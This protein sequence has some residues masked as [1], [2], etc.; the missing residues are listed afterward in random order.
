MRA[1][2]ITR[3]ALAVLFTCGLSVNSAS[4]AAIE[5][6]SPTVDFTNGTWSLGFVFDVLNDVEVTSLGF[7]DDLGNDL[8]ERHEVGIFDSSGNLLVSTFVSP[9]D[10]LVGHF[11]YDSIAPFFL[12]AGTG[13]R[14][15]ATTG[16]ENYTWEPTGFVVDP[17]ISF[18][19]DAFTFSTTLVFPTSSTPLT[20]WFGPNFQ[21]QAVPEPATMLLLGGGLAGMLARR[22]S[23]KA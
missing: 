11:R 14:I 15:A 8:T 16:S 7:Y 20:G 2:S 18:V 3:W 9:G 17:N 19:T 1:K 12:A 10:S 4:A 13:Y 5:F 22:R 21:L 6:T 23:K